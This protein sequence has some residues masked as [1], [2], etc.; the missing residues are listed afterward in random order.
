MVRISNKSNGGPSFLLPNAKKGFGE[1]QPDSSAQICVHAFFQT[2][3]RVL[4]NCNPIHPSKYVFHAYC[5]Q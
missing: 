2:P 3:K 4:V 1:L 5:I